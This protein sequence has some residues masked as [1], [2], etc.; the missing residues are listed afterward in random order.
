MGT[1]VTFASVCRSHCFFFVGL[2]AERSIS[3]LYTC[4]CVSVSLGSINCVIF[5]DFSKAFDAVDTT[6][7][8]KLSLYGVAENSLGWFESY[9]TDRRQ[10]CSVNG[11]LSPSK[12]L[13]RV[14]PQGSILGPL[15]FLIYINDLPNSLQFSTPRMYANDTNITTA[16]KSLNNITRSANSD[17]SSIRQWLQTN[18]L[19]LNVTRLSNF[20]LDQMITSEKLMIRI[21]SH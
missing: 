5:L 8:H 10:R 15:L 14:V 13:T 12:P 1:L 11:E 19:R 20:L 9:L 17:L 18:K 2:L 3:S 7:L 16:G 4:L 6:L 21:T